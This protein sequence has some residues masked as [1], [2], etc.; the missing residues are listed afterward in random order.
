MYSKDEFISRIREQIASE[1]KYSA[2]LDEAPVKLVRSRKFLLIPLF[3]YLLAVFLSVLRD[4]TLENVLVLWI[5]SVFLLYMA[6][7][8]LL[9]IPSFGSDADIKII[10]KQKNCRVVR[11]LR[12]IC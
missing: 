4:H 9:M 8:F 10:D 2:I 3:F 6:N 1:E 7:F 11:I 5:S 12:F